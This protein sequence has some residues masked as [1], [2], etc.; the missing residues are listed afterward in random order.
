[1]RLPQCCSSPLQAGECVQKARAPLRGDPSCLYTH[2]LHLE[3]SLHTSVLFF[4]LSAV[5]RNTK[6]K[7]EFQG[8]FI[9]FNQQNQDFTIHL[10]F[11]TLNSWSS[12]Q[13][14]AATHVH[15][16]RKTHSQQNLCSTGELANYQFNRKPI[17]PSLPWIFSRTISC[18]SLV[19]KV[20]TS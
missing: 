2:R 7:L 10:F 5:K 11:C 15:I 20:P 6:T 17:F 4:L 18:C 13:A 8:A 19:N 12:S 16:Q 1:M 3:A 9:E 14:S